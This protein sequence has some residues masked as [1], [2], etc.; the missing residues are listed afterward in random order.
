MGL[1]VSIVD[2]GGSIELLGWWWVYGSMCEAE[3]ERDPIARAYLGR[4]WLPTFPP[5]LPPS[6]N[7]RWGRSPPMTVCSIG[8]IGQIQIRPL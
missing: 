7:P 2:G 5:P 4:C 3:D 8:K 1:G 6:Q